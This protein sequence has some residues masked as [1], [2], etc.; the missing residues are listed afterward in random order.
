M[1]F[2][3][4]A[5]QLACCP[6]N[7]WPCYLLVES[8]VPLPRTL[9]IFFRFVFGPALRSC[10]DLQPV[11]LRLLVDVNTMLS[12]LII[13]VEFGQIKFRYNVTHLIMLNYDNW[14]S[15]LKNIFVKGIDVM[16]HKIHLQNEYVCCKYIL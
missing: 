14:K 15:N 8:G 11:F 9:C 16:I 6:N 3:Q 2:S 1:T 13:Q 7:H 5:L 10:D 12:N 4:S